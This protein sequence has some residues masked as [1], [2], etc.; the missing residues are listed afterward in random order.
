MPTN[1]NYLVKP[2]D[3]ALQVLTL[4]AEAGRD[5]SL[6]DVCIRTGLPKT[7]AFRYLYT[8]ATHGYVTHDGNADLYRLGPRSWQLGQSAGQFGRLLEVALPLME[9]LRDRFDET[10]NLGVLNHTNVVYLGMVE[11]RRTLRMQAQIGSHDPAYATSLGKAILAFLPSEQW[12][13]HLPARL[14]PRTD[15]T[16]LTRPALRQDL[17]LTRQRG[18][19]LDQGENEE[20]ACCIGA[21]IFDHYNRVIAA[22]SVSAPSSRLPTSRIEEVANVV[23]QTAGKIAAAL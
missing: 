9:T 17:E 15:H 6:K 7:T 8:L 5:L 16:L 11:S 19:A 23:I 12:L 14:T 22:V 3:K 1:S 10:V 20:G 4:L 2:V 21:P 13:T 18:Y